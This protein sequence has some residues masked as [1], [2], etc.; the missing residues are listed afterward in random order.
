[1]GG[2]AA[3]ARAE[4]GSHLE[5]TNVSFAATSQGVRHAFGLSVIDNRLSILPEFLHNKTLSLS[6]PGITVA[7]LLWERL[8]LSAGPTPH[9]G[10]GRQG[11]RSP[12]RSWRRRCRCSRGSG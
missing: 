12:T 7:G 6:E 2:G 1:M 4:A 9:G 11:F 8:A 3:G 5:A 10:P